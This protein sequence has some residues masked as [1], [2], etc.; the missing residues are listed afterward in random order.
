M[1]IEINNRIYVLNVSKVVLS[2]IARKN[3]IVQYIKIPIIYSSQNTL[4]L[5]QKDIHKIMKLNNVL[6]VLIDANH[7][8]VS[9]LK[10]VYNVMT[11]IIS[12]MINVYYALIKIVKNAHKRDMDI[13]LNVGA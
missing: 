9:H 13:A 4:N 10:I 2:V 5:V 11:G 7:V 6:N 3:Q 8:M 12:R 1:N